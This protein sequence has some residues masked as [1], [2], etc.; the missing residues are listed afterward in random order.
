MTA[1]KITLFL[2]TGEAKSLR[3]AEIGNWIGKRRSSIAAPDVRVLS[4]AHET[5]R[6]GE[7]G[8]SKHG[9]ITNIVV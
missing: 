1:E 2:L 9:I 8:A 6:G 3:T 5:F 7:K 4:Q